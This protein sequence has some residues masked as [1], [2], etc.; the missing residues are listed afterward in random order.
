MNT[1]VKVVV[2]MDV[3]SKEAAEKLKKIEHHAEMIL[4]LDSHPEI[5]SV[6][7][8]TVNVIESETKTIPNE[9]DTK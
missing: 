9:E 3:S 4:D 6:Y 5:T 7:G 8:V 2:Y 1:T